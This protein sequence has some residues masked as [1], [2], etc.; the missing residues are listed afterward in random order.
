MFDRDSNDAIDT[1]NK[2]F[3]NFTRL[4]NGTL[5]AN[6]FQTLHEFDSNKDGVI[7]QNDA[8]WSGKQ[9]ALSSTLMTRNILNNYL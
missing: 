9:K 7:D 1:G 3:S 4:A 6:G 8:I 5:A 2:L